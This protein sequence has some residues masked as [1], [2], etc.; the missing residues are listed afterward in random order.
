MK[1]SVMPVVW[2][3]NIGWSGVL[4]NSI[5]YLVLILEFVQFALVDAKQEPKLITKQMNSI[6]VK[7][8]KLEVD[9][10]SI[11]HREHIK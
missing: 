9:N 3:Q 11:L 2:G 6:S 8:T 4:Y 1:P 7:E 10:V 5:R